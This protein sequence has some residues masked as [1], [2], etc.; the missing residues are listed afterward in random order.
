[1]SVE[2]AAHYDYLIKLRLSKFKIFSLCV[3]LRR[4]DRV[5]QAPRVMGSG[6]RTCPTK[7]TGRFAECG[8]KPSCSRLI[9]TFLCAMKNIL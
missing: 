3:L 7:T 5:P 9:F 8:A 2:I 4:D 6:E 1:M